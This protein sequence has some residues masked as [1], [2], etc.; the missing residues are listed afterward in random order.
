MSRIVQLAGC[1]IAFAIAL[2]AAPVLEAQQPV[3]PPPPPIP[4]QILSGKKVFISN[5]SG[6]GAAAQ[7]IPELTYDEFYAGMKSLGR[8]EL[9]G[10]PADADL[11]FEIRYVFDGTEMLRATILDPK[12]HVVLWAFTEII[13][14]A[15]RKATGRKNFDTAM[16]RL[17]NDVRNLLDQ[18]EPEEGQKPASRM[19]K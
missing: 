15:I 9:V 17:M 10:A 18:H 8:Y 14:P 2:G 6:E 4:A 13:E 3:D 5:A 7:G 12:T 11:V 1:C 16:A 19:G